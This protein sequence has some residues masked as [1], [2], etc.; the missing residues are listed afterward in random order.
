[1]SKLINKQKIVDSQARI[2]V[3]I[4]TRDLESGLYDLFRMLSNQT[5]KPSQIV[6]VDNYSSR[7][8]QKEMRVALLNAKRKMFKNDVQI[9]LAF[10]SDGEF[11]HSYSTNLGVHEAS[12]EFVCI[13]NG[14]SLPTSYTWLE[15][16]IIQLRNPKVA[17][18]GGFF[19]PWDKRPLKKL[20]F[21]VESQMKTITWIST[22]NCIIRKSVWKE[23]PFDESLAQSIP[24]T[25]KYGGEDYDWNLGVIS[26][27]HK[28]ALI[29]KFSVVHFHERNFV[30]EIF[31]NLR[32]Y[33]TF[34]KINKKIGSLNRP[35]ISYT[36]VNPRKKY[37]VEI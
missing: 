25:E 8:R 34:R 19:Y 18:V 16:G 37:S 20:S 27:G 17:A 33:L 12:N 21:M 7:D 1:M 28:I 4:R 32:N 24:E 14:H 9:K 23:Y 6:I 15:D 30:A 29:P 36:R 31:R 2:S 5:S 10:L 13:T 3:V 26:M 35:R 22:M 11:S